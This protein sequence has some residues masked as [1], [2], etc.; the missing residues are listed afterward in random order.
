MVHGVDLGGDETTYGHQREEK[1][2][3]EA[4]PTQ[5]ALFVNRPP[6][7]KPHDPMGTMKA[8]SVRNTRIHGHSFTLIN[9]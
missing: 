4:D 2:Q 5:D 3:N 6:P 8:S 1:K 9:T 7:L